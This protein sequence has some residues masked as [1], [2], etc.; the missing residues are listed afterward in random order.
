MK[1]LL[2]SLLHFLFHLGYF[3][4]FV[5]G[6]FDSSFL[7]LPF[8]NDLLVVALT[9]RHHQ[10]YLLYV[11]SAVC[12]STVG[13]FL[14]DIVAR[15][16]G[17]A[18]VTKV[19]GKRRFAYLQKKITQHGGKVL[20]LACL[21]PPP[22]PFTMAIAV[23]SALEYP[24]KRLL[25]IVA[26]CRAVRFLILGALAIRFGR[27]ILHF[28]DSAAFKG[29]MYVFTALCLAGSVYSAVNWIRKSRSPR[30]GGPAEQP[31]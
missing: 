10:G 6:V 1:R 16:L 9:A 26:A 20:A 28:A 25:G 14:L 4:P 27:A 24:R 29:F 11:V 15:K 31:A 18:G 23:T 21:A 30:A 12:G 5:M 2:H 8:G 3:G 19:A 13:V 22:F 17:E 7:F